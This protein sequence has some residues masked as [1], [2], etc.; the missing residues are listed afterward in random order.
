MCAVCTQSLQSCLTLW[1]PVDCCQ[2]A[3]SVRGILQAKVLEWVAM[4]FSRGSSLPRI[5]PASPA[6]QAD[7]LPTELPGKP[8]TSL[9][10]V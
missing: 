9:I 7:S 10:Q 8:Q 5:E 2:P 1:D 6:F 4:P 3:S